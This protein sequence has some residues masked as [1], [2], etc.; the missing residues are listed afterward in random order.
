MS[1]SAS[2]FQVYLIAGFLFAAGWSF[3]L[4]K[5]FVMDFPLLP[6][7]SRDVWTV[8]SKVSFAPS[9]G[10]VNV[11]LALPEEGVGWGVL[12]EH[13]ASSGFSFFVEGDNSRRRARWERPSLEKSAILYYKA[14]IYQRDDAD[15]PPQL[16]SEV[17]PPYLEADQSAAMERVVNRLKEETSGAIEFTASLLQLLLREQLDQD[18]AFLLAGDMLQKQ[19]LSES[20][21]R[22]VL[23]LDALA[24]AGIPAQRIR[25]VFLEDGRR[26]QSLAELVEIYTGN[27]WLVFDPATGI[28]GIPE[29][30]FIWQR[31]GDSILDV[32]GGR[33]SKIEF[34]LVKNTLPAKTVVLMENE[35]EGQPLVDFSIYSLPVEQQGMF[36]G[37]LLIPVGAVVIVLLRVLIGIRTSGTFMPILIAL[38]F[39]Q[40]TLAV[41]LAIFLCVVGVGLWL[42][43]YLSHLNLLLVARV[44]A[45]VIMVILL[46]AVLSVVSYKLGLDQ[47]LSVTFFPTIILAWTIERMSILWE[48]EGG[49]EVLIQGGGS[50]FAAVLA[51]LVMTSRLVEH[52]TFNFPELLLSVLGVVLILGK[53]SGY[54]LFELYRFRYLNDASAEQK[55][56]PRP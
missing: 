4:Y 13:F 41:G 39:M 11:S 25:G 28:Q 47:A 8:E 37:I 18:A 43:N 54:R 33:R 31:G 15:L 3:A 10:P 6:G 12:D 36:K 53:Y 26:R 34:A 35:F 24:T 50:L 51:F 2:R 29:N 5:A 49:H 20:R 46:M 48:E 14:Q 22:V 17:N 1:I 32:E 42:R 7:E 45:V 21:A 30:F 52:L 19:K 38:A 44:T 9:G 56:A 40:T 23:I 55:S 27:E 16:V